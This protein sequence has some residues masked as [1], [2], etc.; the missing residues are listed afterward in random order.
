[1]GENQESGRN[2]EEVEIRAEIGG[3]AYS[4]NRYWAI[5]KAYPIHQALSNQNL[6]DQGWYDLEKALCETR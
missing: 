3:V 1:M 4:S 6:W 5:A 2:E